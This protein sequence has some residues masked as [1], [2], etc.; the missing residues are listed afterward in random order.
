MV[1]TVP[2]RFRLT[3][4]STF[5]KGEGLRHA[6][7]PRKQTTRALADQKHTNLAH[8][9]GVRGIPSPLKKVVLGAPTR[10]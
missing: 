7:A 6:P 9:E 2:F 1:G 4:E 8:R 3:G 10:P 5:P